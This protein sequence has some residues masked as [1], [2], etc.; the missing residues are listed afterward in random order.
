MMIDDQFADSPRGM[1][2]TTRSSWLATRMQ[3]KGGPPP[4]KIQRG[5]EATYDPESG[6]PYRGAATFDPA[7]AVKLHTAAGLLNMSV[8]GFIAE[9]IRRM[10]VDAVGRPA[11]A[12]DLDDAEGRLPL[13]ELALPEPHDDS[14]DRRT[15]A[16]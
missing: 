4:G 2:C 16:A 15:A 10:P 5:R 12:A 3:R 13:P 7:T 6:L 1:R 11:W 9:A 8:S 14:Q